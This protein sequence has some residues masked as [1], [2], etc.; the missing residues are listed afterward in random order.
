MAAN[1]K[2]QG[3]GRTRRAKAAQRVSRNGSGLFG[4]ID[5][6][7]CRAQAHVIRWLMD[8]RSLSQLDA[9]RVVAKHVARTT[10]GKRQ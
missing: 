8:H 3:N 6:E 10:N 5:L 7:A 1:G 2:Q 4:P 9:M